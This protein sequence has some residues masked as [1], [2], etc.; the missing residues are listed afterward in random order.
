MFHNCPVDSCDIVVKPGD[1]VS[2]LQTHD[3]PVVQ[4]LCKDSST[5]LRFPVSRL[6][7]VSLPGGTTFVLAL[8]PAAPDCLLV[9]LWVAADDTT[10]D[11]YRLQLDLPGNTVVRGHVFPLSWTTQRVLDAAAD[12][13]IVLDDLNFDP[14]CTKV[15]VTILSMCDSTTL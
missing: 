12:R 1:L 4:Y 5:Y 6:T 2:H 11:F 13:C 7:T 15:R 14:N 3:D 8:H 10:A 9:W